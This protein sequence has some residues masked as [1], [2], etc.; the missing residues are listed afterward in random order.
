ERR[1]DDRPQ[2]EPLPGGDYDGQL[3]RLSS[4]LT[5]EFVRADGVDLRLARLYGAEARL[6]AA[7]GRSALTSGTSVLV[8]EVDWA[9]QEEAAT[10]VEDVLYRRT[11]AALYLPSERETLVQPI[12]EC[13]R[14]LLDWTQIRLE[15]EVEAVRARLASE[16]VFTG[17]GG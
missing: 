14:S 9:V 6:I 8:G 13:M 15:G 5:R 17:P 11:R 16:T 4:S 3:E 7:R 1:L 2:E 10:C 12:A